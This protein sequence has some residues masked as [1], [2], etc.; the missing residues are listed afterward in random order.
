MVLGLQ[1]RLDSG[2]CM[3]LLTLNSV[4]CSRQSHL[5]PINN[6]SDMAFLPASH[7]HRH[8]FVTGGGVSGEPGC[9]PRWNRPHEY[10]WAASCAGIPTAGAGDYPGELSLTKTMASSMRMLTS[11]LFDWQTAVLF[12]VYVGTDVA[13]SDQK[14][15]AVP[16][17]AHSHAQRRR[18][19]QLEHNLTY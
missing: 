1:V 10:W 18:Q 3:R 17:P 4:K 7:T 2:K 9:G 19:G 14:P 13:S 5:F 11:D 15:P 6:T 16:I 8:E 12:V